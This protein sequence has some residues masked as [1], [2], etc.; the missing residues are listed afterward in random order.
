MFERVEALVAGGIRKADAF[1]QLAEEYGSEFNSIRGA[2]YAHTRS[3]GGSGRTSRSR[4]AAVDPVES[5]VTVLEKAITDIDAQI[6]AAKQRMESA[7][8]EFEHLRETAGERKA[9]IAAKIDALK[10]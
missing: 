6:A 1:R 10:A 9:A 4:K 3:L 8:A 7:K 5:A 2:Y